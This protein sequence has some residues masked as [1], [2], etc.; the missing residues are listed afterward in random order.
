MNVIVVT[1]V[2]KIKNRP[3]YY[4]NLC[5][6]FSYEE[7]FN[8]TLYSIESIRQYFG[9]DH[10]ILLIECSNILNTEWE[11]IL[12]SKVDFYQNTYSDG[13]IR[14]IVE[15]N[16]KNYGEILLLEFAYHFCQNIINPRI[17]IKNIFK[18][19]GRYRLNKTF[20]F[21][22]WDNNRCIAKIHNLWDENKNLDYKDYELNSIFYKISFAFFHLYILFL[23]YEMNDKSD[24][25]K[26]CEYFLRKFFKLHKDICLIYSDKEMLGISGQCSDNGTHINF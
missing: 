23:K 2:I 5:N 8:Q 11:R 3:Q 12:I 20:N 22:L 21:K 16:N 1:S 18:L 19:S 15:S 25:K 4:S 13:T 9:Q 14:K 17:S 10:K 26:N 6:V 7:R 24:K